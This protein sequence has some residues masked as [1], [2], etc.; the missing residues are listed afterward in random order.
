MRA[1][2]LCCCVAA[3]CVPPDPGPVGCAC[4]QLDVVLAGEEDMTYGYPA[5]NDAVRKQCSQRD[6]RTITCDLGSDTIEQCEGRAAAARAA[7]SDQDIEAETSC[8]DAC[9][10]L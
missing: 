2:V 4:T 1:L 10:C 7:L 8:F 9:G 6:G 3:S 5:V